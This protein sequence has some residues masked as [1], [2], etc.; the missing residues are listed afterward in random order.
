LID[1][2]GGANRVGDFSAS[3]ETGGGA[4]A[5]AGALGEGASDRLWTAQ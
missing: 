5:N 4:L 1:G 3:D 2:S